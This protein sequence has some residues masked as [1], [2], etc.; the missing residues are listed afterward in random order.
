[1]FLAR[2]F[3]AT[4]LPVFCLAGLAFLA[5]APL[6][7]QNGPDARFDRQAY[8][9]A[10]GSGNTI[11][12]AERDAL[13]HLV[14]TFGQSIEVVESFTASYRQAVANGATAWTENSSFQ[15][16]ITGAAGMDS[17]VGAQIG[18]RWIEGDTHF[19]AAVLHRGTA[20]LVFTER[21]RANL[22]V[23]RNL[24][25]VPAAERNGF[26]GFSRYQ[27][28]AVFADMS[29]VYSEILVF[30]G[31]PWE[32]E[33]L[34]R[35]DHYRLEAQR[36]RAAI[37]VGVNVRGD[38][39]NR[40]Q[41]AFAGVF[42]GLGFVTGGANPRFVLNV[43]VVNRPTDHG[44]PGV[45]FTQLELSANLTDTATGTVLL[46]YNLSFRGRGHVSQSAAENLTINEA[47]QR[48]AAEYRELVLNLLARMV[49]SR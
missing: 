26:E 7:A 40:I 38:R 49:P 17:L 24:T 46:P 15:Q 47:E 37:P 23:I 11:H 14:R 1:M 48:I 25:A 31:L 32:G 5:T 30:L 9:V 34:R 39:E 8:V 19:A 10:V 36:I 27:F 20:V 22:D 4:T 21:I 45:V 2:L 43:N 3:P 42:S 33:T 18:G 13:A 29:F 28:A 12:A 44:I 41:G 6:V 35:G 16:T